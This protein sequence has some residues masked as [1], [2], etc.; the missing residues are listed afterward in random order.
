VIFLLFN[1][2]ESAYA[3]EFVPVFFFIC[4]GYLPA[5]GF[6]FTKEEIGH[7]Y[8][9]GIFSWMG[10]RGLVNQIIMPIALLYFS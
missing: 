6:I 4:D 10:L 1:L 5:F 9:D 8:A 3:I 2:K 7:K